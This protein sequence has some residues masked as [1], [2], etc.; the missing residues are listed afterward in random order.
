M[1]FLGGSMLRCSGNMMVPGMLN[2]VMCALDVIFNMLLIFPTRDISFAGVTFTMP[3]AGM[4][5]EGAALGTAFAELVTMMLMLYFLCFRTGDLCLKGFSGS[6]MPTKSCLKKAVKIGLPM[7]VEHFILCAAQ[8]LTTV[9]VAPLGTIAIAANAFAITAESLCY[10][11]GYGIGDA[12][13]TLIGQS[14]GAGRKDLT[15]SFANITVGLGM[16]VMTLMGII[17]Y[18]AAPVMMGIMTSDTD[19][20]DLGVMALRIEAYAEPMFAASIVAY[21]VF[22]GAGDTLMPCAMNLFSMWA[23]RLTL[24]AILAPALGLQG[25]WIAMCIEL[26]FRGIIFLIRLK[27]NRWMNSKNIT[28][29]TTDEI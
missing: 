24:A 18:A 9:I 11:P 6:F 13:T 17:M 16:A 22:V 27:G 1:N 2:I 21:G 26:C 8:I 29:T 28:K 14:L 20:I 25:V 12:A 4:G 5:V 3:G 15:R 7:G 19:I 10:M 23:V